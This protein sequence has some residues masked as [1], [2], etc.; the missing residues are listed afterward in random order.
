MTCATDLVDIMVALRQGRLLGAAMTRTAVGVLRTQQL[1]DGLPAYL[2]EDVDVASKT[3][4]VVGLRA[5]MALL[6]RSG[7]WV[8]VAVLADGLEHE[9]SDR[10]TSVLPTFAEIGA[11]AAELLPTA[12]RP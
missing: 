9:G 5:D 10:G 8:V 1:R 4:D 6:E 7:R 11:L 2:P 12:G 3:G